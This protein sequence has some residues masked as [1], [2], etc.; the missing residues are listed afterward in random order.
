MADRKKRIGMLHTSMV[1]I[2]VEPVFKNLFGELMPDVEIVDFIDS[3]VLAAV[4]R[5]GCIL[6]SSVN[7]MV[8][9]AQ[10]A[11]SSEVDLIFSACSSLGP[12]ID[13][14]R[15]SVQTPIIKIDDAMAALAVQKG[16]RIGVLAT[17]PTTLDPTADL[18]QQRADEVGKQ[19]E[20]HK[21][22][23]E[24]AFQTL[25]SG[26]RDKHDQMV[27]EGAKVLAPKVDVLVLAQASMARLAPM[28]SE[29]IGLEVLSS[30]RLAVE[31]VKKMLDEI[32][33]T[34]EAQA[35]C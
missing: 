25:M 9:M 27:L 6:P 22:L 29:Q 16:T 15:K 13:E 2:N 32:P 17:V 35:G 23:C 24:G 31:H 11:E 1:F 18:I 19:I 4:N 8:H 10:A 14:A 30:P 5:D 34:V 12:A 7:R 33:V 21:H 3:D 28:L 26:D 20:I